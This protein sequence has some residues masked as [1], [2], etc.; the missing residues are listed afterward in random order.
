[1]S[2]PLFLDIIVEKIVYRS[3]LTWLL[4]FIIGLLPLLSCKKISEKKDTILLA[5]VSSEVLSLDDAISQIPRFKLL[6]DSAKAIKDFTDQWIEEQVLLL[7]CERLN[8]QTDINVRKAIEKAK[9]EVLIRSLQESVLNATQLLDASEE[10]IASFYQQN[11]QLFILQ[12][13]HVV[14]DFFFHPNAI[15]TA[16]SREKVLRGQSI[17]QIIGSLPISDSKNELIQKYRQFLSR[18]EFNQKAPIRFKNRSLSIGDISD[19]Y[20]LGN[21][22]VFLK[23]VGLEPKGSI[24]GL[25][26]VRD[27]IKDWLI[28]EKQKKNLTAYRRSL[29]L[30]AQSNN[31]IEVFNP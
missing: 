26:S 18:T 13:D 8:L 20:R 2:R 27:R 10:E 7:E 6:S 5:R 9:N 1:M 4:L 17:E 11:P 22:H 15:L 24:A 21:D 30:K 12:E 3:H 25:D 16:A 31:Q 14:I 29:Y 28:T 19:V 23:V